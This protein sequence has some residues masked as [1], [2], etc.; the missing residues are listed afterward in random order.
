[1][2][3]TYIILFLIIASFSFVRCGMDT[4]SIKDN[5]G[6]EYKTIKIGKQIWM[7][8]NLNYNTSSGSWCYD[9]DSL[10]CETFG[11]LYTW[12]T[13]CTICPKGWHLP[14]N[15]EWEEL[16]KHLSTKNTDEE[17]VLSMISGTGWDITTKN[18]DN[19]YNSSGFAA[20]PGGYR[21]YDGKF[22]NRGKMGIWWS[23]SKL[24][25]SEDVYRCVYYINKRTVGRDFVSAWYG[26]SVRC[27]K[28]SI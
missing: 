3:K 24:N 13:A 17:L 2:E 25:I 21:Y 15:E 12:E 4:K 20:L 11:R 22:Y 26:A 9:E 28:D 8:E 7:S 6:N 5:A 1:M 19:E 16:I 18:S 10:Y 14:S 27:V 23:S